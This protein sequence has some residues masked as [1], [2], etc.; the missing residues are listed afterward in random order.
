MRSSAPKQPSSSVAGRPSVATLLNTLFVQSQGAYL[1]LD[2]DTVRIEIDG[3]PVRQIPLHHL[4]GISVFGNVLIS[5]ALLHRCAEDGRSVTW[6]DGQGQFRARLNGPVSGN[7]LLR[8]AQHAA[9]DDPQRTRAL[10]SQF[11]RGKL[12]NA[13]TVLQRA[14]RE[15]GGGPL[16]EAAIREHRNALRLLSSVQTLD[17]IRGIEG[18][19]ATSYFAAFSELVRPGDLPFSGRTRRP[20]RD[21]VNA[22]LSFAYSLVTRD[23]IAALEGVGLDPQIGYLHALRPGRPALA[24]DLVEEL[25][26]WLADRLCLTLI[27][28]RQ[29]TP[30]EFESRPGGAVHLT[31]EGRREVITAYQRRKQETISHPLFKSP[32]PIG[33]VPHVQARLL[34][35]YLR[36]DLPLYPPFLPR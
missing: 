13:L 29:L 19:A 5:T 4:D 21:P 12:R 3:Q 24:L 1:R 8:R 30:R 14:N 10:A 16:L 27:N 20:P 9:L 18:V 11:V 33:L 26:P 25:R 36:D 32:I 28:R 35:R 15:H 22:V 31:E 23:S 7:V 6:F 2:H 17:E 34:A